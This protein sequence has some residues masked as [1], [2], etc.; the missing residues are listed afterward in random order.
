MHIH[1]HTHTPHRHP[2]HVRLTHKHIHKY[3][4]TAHTTQ[5]CHHSP[6]TYHTHLLYKQHTVH[7]HPHTSHALHH[8]HAASV[9][10]TPR[11]HT[12]RHTTCTTQPDTQNTHTG[13]IPST[14]A[15]HLLHTQL[16]SYTRRAHTPDTNTHA[17]DKHP[18][19]PHTP[20]TCTH[21]PS[22][23]H[24]LHTCTHRTPLTR[25]PTPIQTH[26]PLH[27][28]HTPYTNTCVRHTPPP[29]T[30]YTHS[31][32]C[33]REMPC[34]LVRRARPHM[35][36]V[37]PD[38]FPTS[39]VFLVSLIFILGP[40][41]GGSRQHLLRSAVWVYPMPGLTSHLPSTGD[42]LWASNEPCTLLSLFSGREP[43][44]RIIFIPQTLR[45]G[46]LSLQPFIFEPSVQKRWKHGPSCRNTVVKATRRFLGVLAKEG[47][48]SAPLGAA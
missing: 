48:S 27:H 45:P 10:H 44:P 43:I 24:T 14:R 34:Y 31:T 28:T 22:A 9:P 3:T 42:S 33:T 40:L 17:L 32:R 26:M 46:W 41:A 30:T 29:H 36:P 21:T 39:T 47:G 2:T 20:H 1:S 16:T 25:I 35:L 37:C 6:H 13:H 23:Y 38:V 18:H 4:H 5:T 15:T 12:R 7:K 11:I 19:I 8:L